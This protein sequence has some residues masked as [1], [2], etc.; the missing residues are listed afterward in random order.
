MVMVSALM[1]CNIQIQNT[2]DNP[3]PAYLA[4]PIAMS[5][6]AKE[7]KSEINYIYRCQPRNTNA[8]KLQLTL[9]VLYL[10]HIAASGPPKSPPNVTDTETLSGL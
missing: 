3:Q 4:Q 6:D 7:Q 5:N 9:F 8:S 2:M 10:T 1:N